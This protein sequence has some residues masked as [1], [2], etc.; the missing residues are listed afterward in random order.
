MLIADVPARGHAHPALQDRGEVRCDVAEQVRCDLEIVDLGRPN[1][2]LLERV[3]VRVVL[4][5]RRVPRR[6]LIVDL[7][8]E[9]APRGDVRLVHARHSMLPIRWRALPLFRY[10]ES[11]SDHT[12]GPL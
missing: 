3:D 8:E 4:L 9:L 7:T 11:E 2:P 6:D 5:D 10:F 12:L 1:E